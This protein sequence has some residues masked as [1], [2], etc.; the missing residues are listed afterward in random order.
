MQV[1][2]GFDV[3]VNKVRLHEQKEVPHHLLGI[4]S[5]NVI[6]II[7]KFRNF[8][9]PVAKGIKVYFNFFVVP[10]IVIPKR[11]NSSKLS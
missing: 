2:Q 10:S 8:A 1:Y 3:L 9:I 5:S 7:K 11:K 6:F 4:V